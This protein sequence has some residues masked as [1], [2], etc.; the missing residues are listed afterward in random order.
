MKKRRA[1][2]SDFDSP[3]K[4]ALEYFLPFF[5]LYFFPRVHAALDWS[6]GY[7]SLDKELHQL[8]LHAVDGVADLAVDRSIE[9]RS[10]LR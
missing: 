3:W 1:T 6:K 10:F 5:L 9:H 8:V 2:R 4:E 7:E